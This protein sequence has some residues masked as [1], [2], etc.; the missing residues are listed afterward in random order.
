MTLP[1]ALEPGT[2]V[3]LV[4]ESPHLATK[5]IEQDETH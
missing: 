5:E 2:E 4:S 1:D 3:S